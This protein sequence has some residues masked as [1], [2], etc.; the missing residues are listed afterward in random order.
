MK[1]RMMLLPVMALLM[2]LIFAQSSANPRPKTRQALEAALDTAGAETLFR[3][4]QLLETGWRDMEP[5]SLLADSLMRRSARMGCPGAIN[6]IGFSLYN[7]GD[8]VKGLSMIR[9]AASAGEPRAIYNLGVVMQQQGAD[10][11]AVSLFREASSKGVGAAMHAL[12]DM[13]RNG[14][15][16]DK[17]SLKADSLYHAAIF[18][19]W[20]FAQVPL[21]QMYSTAGKPESDWC[22]EEG[23]RLYNH[24]AS[25]LAVWLFAQAASE[26]AQAEAL[27]ADAYSRGVGVEY[28]Y[29]LSLSH[30]YKAAYRGNASAQFIVSEALDFFPDM[31]EQ[32]PDTLISPA[33]KISDVQYWREKAAMGG[34]TDAR[35][36]SQMLLMPQ[37]N[38]LNNDTI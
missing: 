3:M 22:V 37:K 18:A 12:G 2:T 25:Q 8:S 6:R 11:E 17:D 34:I 15:Y 23:L 38:I 36:A 1:L 16:V 27:L 28:D 19:G 20:R 35:T 13:Y 9:K 29:K 10:S 4:A 7:N 32:L 31:L 26:N 5:D 14:R 30:F 33:L 21:L 24:G